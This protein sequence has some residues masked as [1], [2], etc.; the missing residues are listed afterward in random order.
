MT[1]DFPNFTEKELS[2]AARGANRDQK[3]AITKFVCYFH[4]VDWWQLSFGITIDFKSPNFEIHLPFGFI[5]VGWVIPIRNF[6]AY[7]FGIK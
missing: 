1:W 6:K 5:K 3:R 4:F 2:K 7:I